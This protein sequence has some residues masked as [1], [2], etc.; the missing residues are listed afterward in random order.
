VR[1]AVVLAACLVAAAVAS[2]GDSATTARAAC[3]FQ[4]QVFVYGQNGWET[5]TNALAANQTPCAHY[6]VVLTALEADKTRP[7][8]RRAVDFIHSKGTNFHALAEFN[9][10]GWS[11]AARPAT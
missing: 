5:L 9:W 4:A 6:Y 7:R 8:G 11:R 2:S 1:G 3:P 10:T